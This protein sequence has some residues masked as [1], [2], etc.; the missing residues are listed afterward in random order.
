MRPRAPAQDEF[1]IDNAGV[2]FAR[3]A[4][5]FREDRKPA[6]MK[7]KP[8]RRDPVTILRHDPETRSTTKL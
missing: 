3:F 5:R 7:P 8:P 2:R 1:D 6:H 4:D